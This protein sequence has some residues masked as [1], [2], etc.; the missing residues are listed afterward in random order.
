MISKNCAPA[1]PTIGTKQPQRC[2]KV[3]YQPTSR[4]LLDDIVLPF[5]EQSEDQNRAN[6]RQPGDNG[7]NVISEH[8][9]PRPKKFQKPDRQGGPLDWRSCLVYARASDPSTPQSI[10]T[11]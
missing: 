11:R 6:R 2:D 7:E 1:D 4:E 5:L 9:N 10:L 8:V 3:E